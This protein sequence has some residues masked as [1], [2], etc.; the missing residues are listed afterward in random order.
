MYLDVVLHPASTSRGKGRLNGIAQGP[1]SLISIHTMGGFEWS[2][3]GI[4]TW[5]L[6]SPKLS[7]C[8]H[9]HP[10]LHGSSLWAGSSIH[11][12][13]G[14][15]RVGR[16]RKRGCVAVLLLKPLNVPLPPQM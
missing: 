11:V 6:E 12:G 16:E 2:H 3:S 1:R 14:E 8:L 7:L 4:A 9:S 15:L 13:V 5:F 10:P